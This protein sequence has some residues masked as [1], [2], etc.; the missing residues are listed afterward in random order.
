MKP[1]AHHRA[2]GPT[3]PGAKQACAQSLSGDRAEHDFVIGDPD[4][5][6]ISCNAFGQLRAAEATL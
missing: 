1:A 2:I 3:F 4:G 6:S 5:R